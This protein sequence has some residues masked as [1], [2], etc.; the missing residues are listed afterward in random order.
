MKTTSHFIW[1]GLKSEAFS[2]MFVATN[3]YLRENN[4]E[5]SVSFQNPL[6]M[7]ITLYYLWSELPT[8]KKQCIHKD[9]S[10]QE[11]NYTIYANWLDYFYKDQEKYVLYLI[12]KTE[13]YLESLRNH[14]HDAYRVKDIAENSFLFVPHI[15]LCKI[16][17]TDVF[18]KHRVNLENI[19]QTEL[20][21][22]QDTNLS[23]KEIR[24]YAVNSM[25][26][27]EIQVKV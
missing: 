9:I 20:L 13:M 21:K 2:D 16:L 26:H 7:H 11:T 27:P 10:Q 8:D 5:D 4:I 14:F 23:E 22:I 19:V 17:M 24:L 6:S 12:P 25:F 15:T 3:E 18:E 1:V